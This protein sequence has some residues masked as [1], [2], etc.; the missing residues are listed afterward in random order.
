NLFPPVTAAYKQVLE[1]RPYFFLTQWEWF[2]WLG[3]F[4][5]AALL[6]WFRRIARSREL[7]RLE[8][9]CKALLIY[10]AI[11]FGVALVV[12]IQGALEN[13]AELQPLRSLQLL[14]IMLFLFGGGFLA[15]F[16]LRTQVVRWALLFV[17]LCFGMWYAQRQLFPSTPHLEWPWLT[18]R[19]PWVEAFQWIRLNT[20]ED[21][22]FALDPHHMSLPGEDEH[23]F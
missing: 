18:P 4:G 6:E 13:F 11:F 23:G 1:T 9:T 16:V 21:A 14:Y 3:I 19:N 15:K 17:P 7:E 12:S 10:Q 20:P 2:E 8:L 5:P 22:Y